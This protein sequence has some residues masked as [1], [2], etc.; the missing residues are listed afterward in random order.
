MAFAAMTGKVQATVRLEKSAL[1]ERVDGRWLQVGADETVQVEVA[2]PV[3]RIGAAVNTISVTGTRNT[4]KV[5]W[6]YLNTE[7]TLEGDSRGL[8]VK[9]KNA[10][11]QTLTWVRE[12]T[13]SLNLLSGD[14]IGN[15]KSAVHVT[16]AGV[17]YLDGNR[18]L[19]PVELDPGTGPT[20]GSIKWSDNNPRVWT[21]DPKASNPMRLVWKTEGADSRL[22]SWERPLV[23][24][25]KLDILPGAWHSS[26][27]KNDRTDV[28]VDEACSKM[29]RNGDLQKPYDVE[30]TEFGV[31]LHDCNKDRIST[32]NAP[33]RVWE[34]DMSKC[35]RAKVHWDNTGARSRLESVTWCKC[36]VPRNLSPT[37]EETGYEIHVV[38]VADANWKKWQNTILSN[39]HILKREFRHDRVY[40]G[41]TK[42]HVKKL[43]EPNG[44]L[45]TKL[46]W[47]VVTKAGPDISAFALAHEMK[48]PHLPSDVD[49]NVDRRR[50]YLDVICASDQISP[51]AGKKWGDI[52]LDRVQDLA[53]EQGHQ[54]LELGSLNVWLTDNYYRTRGFVELDHPRSGAKPERKLKYSIPCDPHTVDEAKLEAICKQFNILF[55]SPP[56]ARADLERRTWAGFRMTKDLTVDSVPPCL[57]PRLAGEITSYGTSGK[58]KPQ[59]K[60]A[61]EPPGDSDAFYIP[62]APLGGKAGKAPKADKTSTKTAKRAKTD[63][64]FVEENL[65]GYGLR[66]RE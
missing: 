34:V 35:T 58:K 47:M 52:V 43:V 13:R 64:Y 32:I 25:Q 9:W 37:T 48:S 36:T 65:H 61:A 10:E 11:G 41:V 62:P 8:Q 16:A 63:D 56:Q 46:S 3:V 28:F 33:Q 51:P 50:M 5:T 38:H 29:W 12:I 7:W 22:V 18:M 44:G 19:H 24:V 23:N 53:R 59:R 57:D 26:E 17:V 66:P 20:T 31:F 14:W 55:K 45:D 4:K 1:P 40:S 54:V 60:R 39:L 27:K 15:Y 42:D 30:I 21:V 2:F 6:N 49:N